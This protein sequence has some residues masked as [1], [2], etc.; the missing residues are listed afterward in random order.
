M[1][2]EDRVVIVS[3]GANGIGRAT[4]ERML[5]EGAFVA[6]L[7]RE[8]EVA[9]D[10]L[11]WRADSDRAAV[12]GCDVLDATSVD[13]A[14]ADARARFGRIDV[15]AGVAGGDQPVADGLDEAHW[16]AT[17]DLNLHAQ[18]RLI[19]AC[20]AA[21]IETRGAIVLVSSVN[22]VAA[23]G[24]P[25][26]AAAKAGLSLLARNLAVELGPAGVRI[27]VVAP[28]TVRT[29]VWAGQDGGADAMVKLYPLGRVG[30]P[31]DIAAAIAFLAS[32]D[33]SWITGVTLPVD[34]GSLTGPLALLQGP[35][36]GVAEAD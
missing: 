20:R 5:D 9:R 28:G 11:D 17:V 8:P 23:Y 15:L 29:R 21:L 27:N 16:Q 12:F 22:G 33:A 19:R 31:S 2:F 35:I 6:V 1:R 36:W 30:E 7:D 13:R 18:V 24:E 10:W 4:A 34:G 3:G 26:Y 14:V 25:A 32:D